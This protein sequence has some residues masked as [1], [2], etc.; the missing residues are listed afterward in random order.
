MRQFIQRGNQDL[1]LRFLLGIAIAV[2]F[3]MGAVPIDG[4]GAGDIG[5]QGLVITAHG[6]CVSQ[7]VIG[8]AEYQ[9]WLID[10]EIVRAQTAE[11][12]CK[13]NRSGKAFTELAGM[14]VPSRS[15]G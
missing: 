2:P 10:I 7:R 6:R 4:N 5:W 13:R 1:E 3:E 9:Y 15:H 14:G 12:G 11:P 8:A